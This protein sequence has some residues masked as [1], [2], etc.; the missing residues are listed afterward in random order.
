[1]GDDELAKNKLL[2][3][4]QAGFRRWGFDQYI[5]WNNK[6]GFAFAL[7]Q[8]TVG[9]CALL[10]YVIHDKGEER[11]YMIVQIMGSMVMKESQSAF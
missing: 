8:G 9:Y 4:R 10:T 7:Q 5:C 2:L 6:E 3:Q 1:M 11:C